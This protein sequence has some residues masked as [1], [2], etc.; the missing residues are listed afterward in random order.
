[1]PVLLLAEQLTLT[2]RLTFILPPVLVGSVAI[3]VLLPRPRSF[4]LWWGVGLGVIALALVAVL[5]LPPSGP[6]IEVSLFYAFSALAI[7]SGVLLI[8]Q[9]N[10]ARAAIS[11]ALVVLSTCGLFLLLAAPFL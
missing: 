7:L 9:K 5:L 3:F 10:P 2:G 8:S 1:M 4:P 11:F 6:L